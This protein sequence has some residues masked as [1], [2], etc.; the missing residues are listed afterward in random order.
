M[1][2]AIDPKATF[3][4]EVPG[5]E[6]VPAA[7]RVVLVCRYQTMSSLLRARAALQKAVESKNDADYAEGLLAALRCGV[8]EVRNL[9]ASCATGV[10]G[11]AD[12]LTPSGLHDLAFMVAREQALSEQQRKNSESQS[13]G[14]PERS[15]TTAGPAAVQSSSST[16]SAG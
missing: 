1:L 16:T 9:P 14:S 12:V 3:E 13:S 6:D 11:L 5:Q 8:T 2:I 4:I 15:A 7:E 10:D